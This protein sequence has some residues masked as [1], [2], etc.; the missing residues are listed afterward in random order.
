MSDLFRKSVLP[1]YSYGISNR[2][3]SLLA[4]LLAKYLHEE[5][6]QLNNPIEFRN[7]S[8]S[9][10]LQ[11]L[12]ELCGKMELQRLQIAEFNQKLNDI[13]YHEQYFNLN[14]I[15]L[16]ESITG[17]KTKNINE[18]MDNAIVIKIFNDSKQFLIHW[19]I[20]YAEIIFTKLFK[21]P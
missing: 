2:E 16:F 12:M 13:N 10:I 8:S 11:I 17:S 7:N 4:L 15:N 18:A 3:M 20:A 1:V 9:V 14:P 21:Y 5:I 6:K 19:A